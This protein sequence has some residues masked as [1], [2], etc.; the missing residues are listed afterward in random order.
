VFPRHLTGEVIA[1]LDDS[2]VTMLIGARQTGKSTLAQL[3]ASEHRP[4]RYLT[5]DDAATLALAAADPTGFV[6]GLAGPTIIDE[7]QRAPALLPAVKVAVDRDR[8]PG[9][10]FLTGSANVLLLPTVSESLAGRMEIHTLWPLSQGEIGSVRER[11]LE[12]AFGGVGPGRVTLSGSGDIV[13][14][15]LRGGYPPAVQLSSLSRR[16]AWLASY[17]SALVQRDVRDLANVQRLAEFPRLLGLLAS[18]TASLLNMSD[19]SRSLAIPQSSLQRYL[20]LLEHLFLLVRVPPWQANIG[21]RLVKTPKIL[22][23]DTGL[24]SHALGLTLER[25]ARDPSAFGPLLESFVGMELIKQ[26]SWSM[27]RIGLYHYRTTRG[28]EVDFVLEDASGAVVGVEVKSA[29]TVGPGDFRG[30]RALAER[31]GERLVRGIV[32]YRGET[33]VPFG[34][35]LAAWPVETLWAE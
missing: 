1:A 2:P 16:D 22:L 15:V 25:L 19:L 9:R 20:T 7:I 4:A 14:R 8:R 3:I 29:A 6:A 35:R 12:H 24:A 13:D 11:F 33:V 31:L 10:F 28:V 34:E 26:A 27:R 23:N 18:R 21:L 5:L 30:V 32:L 17:V